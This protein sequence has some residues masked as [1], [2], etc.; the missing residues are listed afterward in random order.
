MGFKMNTGNNF[1]IFG[2]SY[3]D[4]NLYYDPMNELWQDSHDLWPNVLKDRY[5]ESHNF[6]NFSKS[7]TGPHYAFNIFYE[8]LF[9]EKDIVSGDI[10]LFHLSNGDRI[11]FA[12]SDDLKGYLNNICYDYTDRNSYCLVDMLPEEKRNDRLKKLFN[13][14]N[15]FRSEID[16]CFL[17]FEK[18]ILYSG[19]KAISFLYTISR[20]YDIKIILFSSEIMGNFVKMSS[21]NDKNFFISNH[22]LFTLSFNELFE[23]NKRK[24][25]GR[26]KIDK[27]YNHFSIE[28]HEIMLE[29][30]IKIIKNDY[31]N[32]P[33]FKENFKTYDEVFE[34]VSPIRDD[35]NKRSFIY[36]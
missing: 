13:Y 28:N 6:Y 4:T 24:V 32:L 15:D 5:K 31:K 21:L 2:D 3:F 26:T 7:G 14:Y 33:K 9:K 19:Q 10:I 16:F 12:C 17:T 23:Q 20:L 11:D 29:Y 27:R 18:E 8:L 30:I 1:Y 25:A 34:Y 35:K 36:E 22:N